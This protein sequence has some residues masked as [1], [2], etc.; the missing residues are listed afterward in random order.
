MFRQRPDGDGQP[1]MM[2]RTTHKEQEGL[3]IPHVLIQQDCIPHYRLPVFKQLT[4]CTK[5]NVEFIS[6]DSLKIPY[7]KVADGSRHDL[8]W[9]AAKTSLIRMPGAP[10]M[11]WQPGAIRSLW[12]K[13]PAVMIAQGS[14][15]CL[16][17]WVL[18]VL[19]RLMGIPVL[20]WGHGLLQEEHGIKWRLR[21]MLYGLASGQL[22]Y[23]Q[24]AR[25]LL[26]R[27]GFDP[28]TL[29][30]VYNSLDYD[31]QQEVLEGIGPN[32]NADV[33]S[34]LGITA[35]MPM[36]V[37]TGRL[38]AVKRLDMLIEAIGLL[39]AHGRKVC[40]VLVGDGD[41]RLRLQSQ[42]E[43]LEVAEQIHF[44]GAVYD[45]HRLGAIISAADL[46][47]VPSGA[48]LSIMH[49][50][51]FGT[52]V[53]IND[54]IECH[55]P[56]WEAVEE[57]KTG[58][59]YRYGDVRDLAEKIAGAFFPRHLKPDMAEQCKAIIRERYNPHRQVDT[60]YRAVRSVTGL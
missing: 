45:E 11:T 38:Q 33:R 41:E 58:F 3:T 51:S 42:A 24:R 20:L 12:T 22:L 60:I 19:G 15:N 17:V 21:K 56:E 28:A 31:A 29:H 14:I 13:R 18:C 35:D 57:G 44:L 10:V 39:S 7:L 25:D 55:F 53:L 59:F 4:L 26:M 34:K 46:A 16:T 47:V 52:P 40:A 30:V 43:T 36:I 6:D 50:L 1:S 5:M 32:N 8:R 49:A 37:F 54:R 2:S 27:H 48:G 23:G 9:T